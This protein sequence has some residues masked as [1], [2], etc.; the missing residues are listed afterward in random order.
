MPTTLLN[1]SLSNLLLQLTIHPNDP[2]AHQFTLVGV[3]FDPKP[4][5]TRNIYD[6]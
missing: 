6:S 1:K 3:E 5:R 4:K 2:T